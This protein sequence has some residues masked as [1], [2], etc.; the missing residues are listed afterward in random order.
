[1]P[2][3]VHQQPDRIPAPAAP[4]LIL[5]P[6]GSRPSFLAALAAG[7]E[8]IYCG[9][10]SFSARMEARNF[11]IEELCGLVDLAHRKGTRVYVTLNTLLKPDEL[12]AAGRLLDQ[13]GR[14]VRPDAVIVQDLAMAQLVRQTGF[15]GEVHWS[16]LANV[17][18]PAA[19]RLIREKLP[20]DSL[21]LPREVTVDEIKAVAA[22]CP[23]GLNLEVF[24][25]GALCYGVSGRCYWSSF[26]GGKSGLRGRCVQPCRRVYAQDRETRRFF[27]CLDLSI[28]VLVKVLMGIPRIR[29]W[30][31]EGRKKGPH[32]VFYVV[33]GYRLLRDHGGDPQAKKDALHFLSRALGRPGTH[34]HFLPQRPQPPVDAGEQ[35]GSGLF[36]GRTH[37]AGRGAFFSPREELLPGDLLRIGYEDAP[38]HRI[39]RVGRAVPKGGRYTLPSVSGGIPKGTAVFLIDR[40]ERALEELLKGLEAELPAVP[41]T[42]VPSSAFKAELPPSARVSLKPAELKVLRQPPRPP[43]PHQVGLWL[44]PA[45]LEAIPAGSG[46]RVWW[47]LP[48]VLF[49]DDEAEIRDLIQA[50]LGRG[51]RTF[52]L[53][54]PWQVALFASD[55]ADVKLWAGPFCNLANPLALETAAA[56]GFSGAVVSPELASA[57]FLK[58]PGCS[59]LPLGVVVG[60]NWPLCVARSIA[61]G[62]EL[63]TSLRSPK[64]EEA[65]VVRH[66]SLYWV[67]PN[68]ELDLREQTEALRR[69]G[70]RLFVRL[71]E[72]LPAAVRRK[73][74]PGLWNWSGELL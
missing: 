45:A 33:S 20:I 3:N 23:P 9:L 42:N 5:A 34:Y 72:P 69:A 10:K 26:L 22:A 67:F 21:V 25:H 1:M 61:Q 53:N 74:R 64:G 54:D 35:T 49:P 55:E 2:A 40:R 36:I 28:D 44:S 24:I 13:L 73:D 70:Y 38:G 30:K 4:P 46:P 18:F 58:L 39:E 57:D 51:S 27:S 37:A 16:T 32:Y 15:E 62:I 41:A 17:S 48:P 31:I 29:T 63:Q 50:A 19:L 52:V 68:W 8:A 59:P 56:L 47:W 6:A 66:G 12:D 11:S 43:L 7:A 60:G 65:W 14:E 71:V